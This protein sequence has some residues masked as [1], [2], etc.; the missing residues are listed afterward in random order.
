MANRKRSDNLQ[1]S[2]DEESQ[3]QSENTDPL[4]SEKLESCNVESLTEENDDVET[5]NNDGYEDTDI[6]EDTAESVK[7][8]SSFVKK[9]ISKQPP[10]KMKKP[11]VASLIQRS[12]QQREQRA[13]E[14]AIERK[15]FEDSKSTNDPLYNFFLSMYQTTQ[16]MPPA[17]QHFVRSKIFEVVSQTEASLLNFPQ[18]PFEE[19]QIQTPRYYEVIDVPLNSYSSES[20]PDILP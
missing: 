7:N 16:K 3:P 8:V 5:E 6:T 11:D 4:A 2:D 19:P 14:R 17:S 18:P 20:G 9:Q 1:H 15:K 10:K 13:K 12:I